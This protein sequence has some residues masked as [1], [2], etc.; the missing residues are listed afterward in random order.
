MG[1]SNHDRLWITLTV[2]VLTWVTL[3]YVGALLIVS[4]GQNTRL[5][6]GGLAQAAASRK[7]PMRTCQ[8]TL[9]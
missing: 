1:A 6:S 9:W 7:R 8:R 5:N 3:L 4:P 2:V